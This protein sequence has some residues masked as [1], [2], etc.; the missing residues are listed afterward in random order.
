MDNQNAKVIRTEKC[1]VGLFFLQWFLFIVLGVII[2]MGAGLYGLLGLL[3]GLIPIINIIYAI[4][5]IIILLF[6]L[7]YGIS[8]LINLIGIILN[9]ITLT[10]TGVCGRD[11]NFKK[12]DLTFDQITE[13]S[14]GKR[15][16][17]INYVN[18][19]GKKKKTSLSCI[20][21]GKDFANACNEQRFKAKA[22]PA[23]AEAEV[24][25]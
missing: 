2:G 10:E 6:S 16:L 9:K 1:S 20:T 4:G 17:I 13:V 11:V 18:E 8:V 7:L 19:N 22:A 24:Q 3:V 14:Y 12:F 25:A 5:G 15:A 21:N 23:Q